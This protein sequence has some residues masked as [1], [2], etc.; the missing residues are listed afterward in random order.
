MNVLHESG[1]IFRVMQFFLSVTT[2]DSF[3]CT[4]SG[5]MQK[6]QVAHP[7]SFLAYYQTT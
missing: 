4:R 6:R 1:L 5:H 3:Y 2:F 7:S